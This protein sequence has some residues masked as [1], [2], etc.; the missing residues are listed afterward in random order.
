MF[1]IAPVGVAETPVGQKAKVTASS[2]MLNSSAVTVRLVVKVA[3][4]SQQPDFWDYRGIG[5][6]GRPSSTSRN[7]QGPYSTPLAVSA[8][9][10]ALDHGEL[11]A[12]DGV[13]EGV[14]DRRRYVGIFVRGDDKG[15]R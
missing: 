2:A 14:Q 4:C 11:G 9:A 3:S 6:E 10:G 5:R 8:V 13:R 12:G 15:R 1:W 7:S